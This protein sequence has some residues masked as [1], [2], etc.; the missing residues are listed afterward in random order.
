MKNLENKYTSTGVSLLHHLDVLK[1]IQDNVWKPIELTLA[2]IDKCNL[3][4]LF[5][6]VKNRDMDELDF[7]ELKTALRD[8]RDIGLKSVVLSGGGEPTLYPYINELIDYIVE[9]DMEVGLI[10]N[11][12][13]LNK[14]V[15][16][17]SL[18]KL[19]WIRI[20]LNSL[21]YVNELDIYLPN[22]DVG[23][24]Y[25]W[26][27]KTNEKILNKIENFLTE[28]S[29]NFVRIVPDCSD[30]T[31][32][33]EYDTIIKQTIKG[34]DKFFYQNKDRSLPEFC[35]VG[36]IKPY[37]CPDGNIYMCT[38]HPLLNKKV[39]KK[40]KIG[41]IKNIKEIWQ[42]PIEIFNPLEKGCKA[43]K[44]FFCEHNDIIFGVIGEHKHKRFV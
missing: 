18:K 30:I 14:N 37:L 23:V 2:P 17:E 44:C 15:T 12:I 27:E 42:S 3:N 9:W 31:K 29:V 20:S 11:G 24:S 13:N 19:T 6:S 38:A 36:Y 28:L 43:G 32:Q 10:T 21:D 22:I 5:C 7:E 34:K 4:C 33:K 16:D 40:F 25:V 8:F 35:A 41:N 39:D 26:N 1:S